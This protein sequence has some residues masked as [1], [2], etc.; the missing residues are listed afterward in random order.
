M[1]ELLLAG[2]KIRK[3]IVRTGI[4]GIIGIFGMG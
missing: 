3:E 1:R 4:Y 2:A